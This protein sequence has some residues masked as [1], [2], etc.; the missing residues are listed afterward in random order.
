MIK[1]GG[2]V[3]EGARVFGLRQGQ[4]G[5]EGGEQVVQPGGTDEVVV[6]PKVGARLG[7]REAQI[8]VNYRLGGYLRVLAYYLH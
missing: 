4:N 1:K 5:M 3:D 2:H 8:E 6:K 7:V